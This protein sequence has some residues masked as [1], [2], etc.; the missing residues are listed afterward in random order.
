MQAKVFVYTFSFEKNHSFKIIICLTSKS[1]WIGFFSLSGQIPNQQENSYL[2]NLHSSFL[3]KTFTL[4]AFKNQFWEPP[5]QNL[6]LQ[7]QI[8]SIYCCWVTVGSTQQ[9]QLGWTPGHSA[10]TPASAL[11][12]RAGARSW[13]DQATYFWRSGRR[14][15]DQDSCLWN[16]SIFPI[17]GRWMAFRWKG[18]LQFFSPGALHLLVMETA[19]KYKNKGRKK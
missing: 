13:P 4:E 16:Y 8:Q 18:N 2:H 19:L 1:F 11:F 6:R 7:T 12:L 17:F 10:A 9:Q 5:D 14:F 3:S 15:E